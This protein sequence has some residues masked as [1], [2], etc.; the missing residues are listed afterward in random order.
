[1]KDQMEISERELRVLTRELLEHHNDIQPRFHE[2][3]AELGEGLRGELG[4]LAAR[5]HS[6]ASRRNF[7]RGGLITAGA[8]GGGLVVAAC[9]SSSSSSASSSESS[10]TPSGASGDLKVAQ[11][12][13]SL[14]VLAVNT[15]GA[16]LQLAGQGKLGAGVPPSFAAFATTVKGQHQDHLNGWNAALKGA[17]L[18]EQKDPDPVYQKVV[19][20]A[21]PG[22]KGVA[23]VAGLAIKLEAVALETYTAGSG[24]LTDKANR[25]VALTIAPVEAQHIA[26]LNFVLGQYP[27][28]DS[29]VKTDQAAKAS[30]LG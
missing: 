15:Y 26:I 3:L 2:R 19:N 27:V 20:D 4:K 17:G 25:E 24:L 1:M 13:A 11:L 23:D 10:G 28:P 16:A 30:D 22:L 21:V 5:R 7:L 8:L 9:G 18:P 6:E 14:E 12:A 29:F